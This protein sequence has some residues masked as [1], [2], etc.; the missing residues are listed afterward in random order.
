ME[1][2]GPELTVHKNDKVRLYFFP[3]FPGKRKPIE[4]EGTVSKQ[5][6]SILLMGHF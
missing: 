1:M 5:A 2:F 6:G 3:D 4:R